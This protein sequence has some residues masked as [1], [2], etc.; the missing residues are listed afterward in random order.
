MRSAMVVSVDLSSVQWTSGVH[1][2]KMRSVMVAESLAKFREFAAGRGHDVERLDA[3]TC[4]DL[5]TAWYELERCDEVD[6]SQDG[7]MLLFEWG[8]YDWGGRS[9]RVSLTRQFIIASMDGDD[10]GFWQLCCEL[11][12]P[13]TEATEALGS[14][15][16]WCD[17]PDGLDGFRS[18]IAGTAADAYARPHLP[19]KV[20]L[21]L[22]Q[23][24]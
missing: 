18:F 7:D 4:V 10:E 6:M 8:T 11:H 12:Y 17:S 23:A 9:F 22:G 19:M 3:A 21:R 24:G 13:V 14:G 15:N 20:E 2:A 16:Q 1:W 5:M